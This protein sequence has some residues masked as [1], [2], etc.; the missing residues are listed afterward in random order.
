MK[1]KGDRKDRETKRDMR[2][3][4]IKSKMADSNSIKTLHVNGFN[5][6]IKGQ[7]LD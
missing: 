1:K 4:E 5:K 7:K 3:T 2:H 6:P